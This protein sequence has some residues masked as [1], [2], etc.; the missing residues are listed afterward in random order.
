VCRVGGEERVTAETRFMIGSSTKPLTSLMMAKLVDLGRFGW[1]TPV[2]EV[3]PVFA[4]A[5]EDVTRRLEMRHT[6]SASTGMPRRDLDLVFRFRGVRPEERIA[7]MREMRPT[8]GFGETFQ[9]S[10]Y[11]VAAGGYAAAHSYAPELPLQ[12]AYD[13]AMREL[14]FEPL[15]MTRSSVPPMDSGAAAMPHSRDLKGNS[16]A[17][18]PELERFAESVAP[19]GSVWS[20]VLDM[21]K[22]LRCELSQGRNDRGE[23][24]IS[25]ESLLTRRR[26]GIKI[27]GKSSYGLGLL[28][29][30]DQGLKKVG[31]GG[32]TRGFTAEMF[33]QPEQQTGLVVL[34]NLRLAN[35]FHAAVGQRLMELL[36]GAESRA[37]AMVMAEKKAL[38]D[39]TKVLGE[40]I[41]TDAGSTAWIAGYTGR[42]VCEELGAATILRVGDGFRIELESGWSALGVEEQASTSRQI[43]LTTAPWVSVKLQV[44]ED[45]GTLVLDG[46][47]KKYEFVRV[48]ETGMTN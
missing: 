38:E 3:L 30:E 41:K 35:Q 21:A 46:G 9:Y 36:F 37:E 25:A 22:Y 12:E 34:T 18:D 27:D 43:V 23:Q 5:D 16:V 28:L 17:I 33:F 47:Q 2:T 10:N 40:R 4:L 14:V 45:P 48:G 13:R 44:T 31:H 42:Y 11:L 1:E 19:A 20:N 6:M 32:N 15:G 24:V 29:T 8:T 39:G 7:E 26:P